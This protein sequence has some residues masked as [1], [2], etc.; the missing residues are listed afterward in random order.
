MTGVFALAVLLLHISKL[1]WVMFF[2]VVTHNRTRTSCLEGKNPDHWT[3]RAV[4]AIE[5]LLDNTGFLILI[6]KANNGRICPVA[7]Y[8]SK[9]TSHTDRVPSGASDQDYISLKAYAI[10]TAKVAIVVETTNSANSMS[11]VLLFVDY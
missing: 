4:D 10:E 9:R 11:D 7:E 1:L 2:F 8:Q 5:M 3:T 6:Y